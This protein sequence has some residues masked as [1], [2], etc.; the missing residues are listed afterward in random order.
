RTTASSTGCSTSSMVFC[1][2]CDLPRAETASI[3]FPSAAVSAARSGADGNS[4]PSAMN[5]VPN[6]GPEAPPT[7]ITSLVPT[8]FSASGKGFVAIASASARTASKPR[9]MFSPWSPSPIAWSN[10]VNS[11]A[12]DA[13]VSA[14]AA[15]NLE[16]SDAAILCPSCR[17]ERG[18]HGR[19]RFGHCKGDRIR[20]DVKLPADIGGAAGLCLAHRGGRLCAMPRGRRGRFQPV[21]VER[22]ERRFE[23]IDH[24]A[25][26]DLRA[27]VK[28][29]PVKAGEQRLAERRGAV[30][31]LRRGREE[32][33]HKHAA[34]TAHRGAQYI[35]DCGERC[36]LVG[37][38]K[39]GDA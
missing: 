18:R 12:C 2:G 28:G 32:D 15:I 37:K 36:G 9:F 34:G 10:A 39:H 25:V 20:D 4:L 7:V 24:G 27:A 29:H 30:E 22:L 19:E 5:S 23:R 35:A 26:A 17:G 3:A 6:N 33:R 1:P 38:R 13:M 8:A 16:K 31:R 21:C 11:S 14:A